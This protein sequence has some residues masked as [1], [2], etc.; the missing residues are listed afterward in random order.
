MTRPNLYET[1]MTAAFVKELRIHL[2]IHH[3]SDGAEVM[4]HETRFEKNGDDMHPYELHD[5]ETI[6]FAAAKKGCLEVWG[7]RY[8][9]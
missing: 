3:K 2:C 9:D 6:M 8:V 1:I 5:A 7:I 4:K